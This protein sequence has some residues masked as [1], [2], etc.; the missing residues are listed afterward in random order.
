MRVEPAQMRSALM[1]RAKREIFPLIFHCVR[2]QQ[3]GDHLQTR[4]HQT[5]NLLA[6]SVLDF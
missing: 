1:G 6:T 3:A 2:I 4:S 5:L